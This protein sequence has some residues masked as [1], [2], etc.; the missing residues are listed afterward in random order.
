ML[1][2]R[3]VRRPT[4]P[5][6]VCHTTYYEPTT[7]PYRPQRHRMAAPGTPAANPCCHRPNPAGAPSNTPAG[8][9][10]TPS[11]TSCTPAPLGVCCP[12]PCRPTASS[13]TTTAPGNGTSTRFVS[14]DGTIGATN[15]D[16][17]VHA[18]T[19]GTAYF[20]YALLDEKSGP[21]HRCPCPPTNPSMVREITAAC[22]SPGCILRRLPN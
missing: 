21:S 16:G 18:L 5:A 7:L 14:M 9:S 6:L 10:P 4:T 15:A 1:V 8:K 13:F 19:T 17:A 20:V 22:T 12:T 11:A 3:E 2:S